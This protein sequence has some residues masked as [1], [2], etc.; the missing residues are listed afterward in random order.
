MCFTRIY[1]KLYQL[2]LAHMAG[3][4][5]VTLNEK[6]LIYVNKNGLQLRVIERSSNERGERCFHDV[7]C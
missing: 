4:L 7:D 2:C 5:K 1:C 3:H 6:T